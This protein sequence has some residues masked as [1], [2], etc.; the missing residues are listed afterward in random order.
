MAATQ[1]GNTEPQRLADQM[2]T[3]GKETEQRELH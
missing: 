1:K 2:Q 3:A